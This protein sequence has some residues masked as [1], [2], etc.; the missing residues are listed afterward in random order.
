[1]PNTKI[2]K[3]KWKN[4][5]Q[6]GKVIYI[7]LII[8]GL[9]GGSMLFDM[10]SPKTPDENKVD[11]YVVPSAEVSHLDEL[12]AQL[13]ADGQEFERAEDRERGID[14][15]AAD[16]AP[17]LR[18]VNVYTIGYNE[19]NDDGYGVQAFM[20]RTMAAEGDVYIV[21]R[22]QLESLLDMAGLEPLDDF[23]ADGV[24]DPG[25]RDLTKVT[26]AEWTQEGQAPTG[27]EYV[28]ALQ[29]E[30]MREKLYQLTGLD[31][32]D[33]FVVIMSYSK[34]KATAAAVVNSLIHQLEGAAEP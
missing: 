20:V 27:R 11:I 2:T 3:A 16:Y 31:G 29:C 17:A 34:N 32:Q 24:I 7:A 12:R 14:V 8:V 25:D 30:P 4:H 5:M 18:E 21:T 23:I 28:Y 15:D 19:D 1:M 10:T 33:M 13:L 9:M 26:Y 22:K 6:Y